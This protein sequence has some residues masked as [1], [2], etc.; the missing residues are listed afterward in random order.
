MQILNNF[1][2]QGPQTHPPLHD[3][4]RRLTHNNLRPPPNPLQPPNILQRPQRRRNAP[5]SRD[6]IERDQSLREEVPMLQQNT[7]GC[8]YKVHPDQRV[9]PLRR[10]AQSCYFLTHLLDYVDGLVPCEG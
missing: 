6:I 4:N 2:N 9:R 10:G 3:Q 8:R 1:A 5:K 7:L